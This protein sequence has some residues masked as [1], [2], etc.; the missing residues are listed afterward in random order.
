M[1]RI[2]EGRRREVELRQLERS[3]SVLYPFLTV[4]STIYYCMVIGCNRTMVESK[5]CT[6]LLFDKIKVE[7]VVLHP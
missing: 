4:L 2:G 3:E 7:T 6:W 1:S 5:G